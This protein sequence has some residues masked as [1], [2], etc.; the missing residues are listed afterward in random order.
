[1]SSIR[2]AL[3]T[4]SAEGETEVAGILTSLGAIETRLSESGSRQKVVKAEEVTLAGHEEIMAL[5]QEGNRLAV[6]LGSILG[7]EPRRS[8]FSSGSATGQAGRG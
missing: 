4:L 1:M 3:V 8:A 5:R 6:T 2:G 7:V